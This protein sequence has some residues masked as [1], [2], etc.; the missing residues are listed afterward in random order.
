M[1][2]YVKAARNILLHDAGFANKLVIQNKSGDTE[3]SLAAA[4]SLYCS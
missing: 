1:L 3:V 2:N 4:H